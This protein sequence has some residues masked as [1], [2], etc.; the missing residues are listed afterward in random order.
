MSQK[1]GI[2]GAMETEVATLVAQL[3][4]DVATTVSSMTFHE[5]TLH[6]APVVVVRCGMGKVNA[7]MCAQTLV[8]QFGATRVINTGVAGSLDPTLNI[9][10]LVVSV[11]A[12]HHDMD[13][14]GLGYPK[15]QVPDLDTLAFAASAELRQAVCRAAAQV[16]P[17]ITV[18]EG[19]VVS[20]DQ[21]VS[22]AAQREPII[23]TFAASCCEMEGAAIAQVCYRNR[24]PFV[25]VRAI[26]DKADDESAVDYPTF[27][28]Q[29]AEHCARIVERTLELLG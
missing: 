16:A 14:T 9:G 24:V 22:S 13:V 11:D 6:G 10:D 5:G 17:D 3:E 20:G 26:S 7:A 15:G 19:R 2:I 4:G 29:A 1:T 28:R 23:R 21:F 18:R 8:A 27:E 25:I 12:L